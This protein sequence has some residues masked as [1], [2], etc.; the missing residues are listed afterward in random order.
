MNKELSVI[1]KFAL[2]WVIGVELNM[3]NVVYNLSSS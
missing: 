2:F 1:L 3:V